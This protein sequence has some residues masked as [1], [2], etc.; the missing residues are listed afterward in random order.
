[1]IIRLIPL[2][3]LVLFVSSALAADQRGI[4]LTEE[5]RKNVSSLRVTILST[6]LA[7]LTGIGEWGF[8]ALVEADGHRVLFDTGYY[9]DTVLE[10]ARALGIKLADVEDVVLSHNHGDHTGGLLSLRK[11]L[12]KQNPKALQRVHVARG[13]FLKRAK[14]MGYSTRMTEM[15]AAYEK[16]G[17]TFIVYD[18]A[19]EILPG[20]W[21]TGPVPRPHPERNWNPRGRLHGEQGLVADDVPESQSLVLD[22]VDGL[23]MISGCGHAGIIN[24]MEHATRRIRQRDIVT[25][26]GGFH[27]LRATD[28]H[29][30]WTAEKMLEF[31]VRDFIGAHCTGIN[32]VFTL[33]ERLGL[34]R[35]HAVVGSVGASYQLGQGIDAGVIAR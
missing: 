22:T 33:R 5:P 6:M 11:A 24:T 4:S 1:M 17:G 21:V 8:A 29:L 35:T 2:G 31:G 15:R 20:M 25:A 23:V 7:D 19:T 26:I 18:E 13:I 27:L 14:P 28:E 3:F 9:P 16:T 32:S 34:D 10:N 30:G 12:A